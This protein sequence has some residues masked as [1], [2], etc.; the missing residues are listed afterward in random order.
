MAFEL[1]R[2]F[3][4][5]MQ[6][7]EFG[8]RMN[9]LFGGFARPEPWRTAEYP[10]LNIWE[11]ADAYHLEAELPGLKLEDIEVLVQ[12]NEVAIK[13]QR[14]PA[15]DQGRTWHRRERTACS[16]ERSVRL[17][18]PPAGEKVQARFTDGVLHVTLPKSDEAKPR[19]IEVKA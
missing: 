2:Q 15:E 12:A 3:D 10:P 19:K 1:F 17:P 5:V 8:E 18:V 14:K 13:G 6:M 16:F 9:R 4:P 11:D 7:R